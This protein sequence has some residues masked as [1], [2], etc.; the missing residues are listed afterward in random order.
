M[1][2]GGALP[3]LKWPTPRTAM[4]PG[5]AFAASECARFFASCRRTHGYS[6]L[7]SAA[8]IGR[9]DRLDASGPIFACSESSDRD[10]HV[11]EDI[12]SRAKR[13]GGRLRVS[14]PSLPRLDL[15]LLFRTCVSRSLLRIVWSIDRRGLPSADHV[16]PHP[17][18]QLR[19]GNAL[20]N[21]AGLHR[22]G[23]RLWLRRTGHPMIS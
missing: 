23:D 17:D 1:R 22:G 19:R 3:R 13:P 5:Y 16:N 2:V 20:A 8:S 14:A 10:S 9:H 6:G 4:L 21:A 12:G 7:R 11:T 15:R 18:E